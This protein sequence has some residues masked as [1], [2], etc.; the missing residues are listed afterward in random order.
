MS[1]FYL[2]ELLSFQMTKTQSTIQ[3]LQFHHWA[4]SSAI[5]GRHL[6]VS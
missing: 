5:T 1:L 2:F 4:F 3:A 6:L